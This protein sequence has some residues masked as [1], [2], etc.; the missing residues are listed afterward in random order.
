MERHLGKVKI[1][2]QERDLLDI[3][4]FN[5][6]Y[7][8]SIIENHHDYQ[9]YTMTGLQSYNPIYAKLF[10]IN[11]SGSQ[12]VLQHKYHIN[13]L[14]SVVDTRTGEIV[15]TPIFVKFSP[16]LDPIK[17][18]IG[19]YPLQDDKIRTLPSF[20]P[21]G[22]STFSKLAD[23]NN[24]SYIDGFFSYLSSQLLEQH[25]FLHGI[26]YYGSYLGVQDKFKMNASD[27]IEY[28]YTS[29]YFNRNVGKH[30]FISDDVRQ[31][32]S[33]GFGSRA[34]KNKLTIQSDDAGIDLGI[35]DIYTEDNAIENNAIENN[36]IENNAIEEN[37]VVYV[38]STNSTQ[39][40]TDSSN[41]SEVIYSSSDESEDSD[42]QNS[43]SESDESESDESESECD[44]IYAFLPKFPVQMICLEKCVGTFDHLLE[45]GVIDDCEGAS[46]LFQIVMTL[47]VYQRAFSFTHNDLHTNNIMYVNTDIEYLYYMWENQVYRVPTYGK[48]YKIIDFG[49]SIYR[50]EGKTFCSD[51]FASGG[52][53]AT[54][55]NCEPYMNENR[56]R[57]DPNPAFDLCRL[58]CS[59]Y[60][61]LIEDESESEM[62]DYQKTV[63]RW[64]KDDDGRNVL[65]K[66][67][68]D[69][70]YPNFKLYK[71]IARIAHHHSP[72]EQL[73]MPLFAQ[74]LMPEKQRNRFVLVDGEPGMMNIDAIP[75][76]V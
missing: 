5:S 64:C 76:Y 41:N 9:P 50:Y 75:S 51:S 16:L 63:A 39:S 59:M 40:S 17:Y 35:E 3:S 42:S 71:M 24:A 70:R 30:F 20:S 66:R 8:Y 1:D 68:G 73:K 54:Q 28:L 18:M 48:I 37:E 58:G 21:S 15:E 43:E 62:D 46:A 22:S 45:K 11:K 56:P 34:N 67:N 13:N 23:E 57:L 52:D 49:R 65:Y 27:D 12:I 19:K 25:G 33:E 26:D 74:F 44:D 14:H 69:E 32:V 7:S 47:L 53:A 4:D 29:D 36:A 10:D 61:F 2:Y 6:Q 60:D 31:H 72:Q 55:Y 38:K